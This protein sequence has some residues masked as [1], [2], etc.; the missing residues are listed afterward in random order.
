MIRSSVVYN[1]KIGVL[2]MKYFRSFCCLMLMAL[3]F[4]SAC[5]SEDK[6]LS[7]FF[8]EKGLEGT[9]IIS[10]L[11][12]NDEFVYNSE[13]SEQRFLPAS[14]F[15]IA[16]TLI[17]LEEEVISN[18]KEIIKW[19]GQNKGFKKWNRDHSLK[20]AFPV[21]CVWFYQELASRI[22]NRKYRYH[23]NQLK[24]GNMET[25][26]D[27]KSFWLKGDLKISAKEQVE[28]LKRLYLDKLPYKS[29][30]LKLVKKLMVIKKTSK[31]VLRGK[32]GWAKNPEKQHGWYVGYLETN[33][34][35][36]FFANNIKINKASDAKY[37]E[38]LV[39]K[40]F[41]AKGII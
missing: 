32:T 41:K 13:R 10:L 24:Y 33:G 30:Y 27:L 26:K 14:T 40:A 36:W 4:V 31:Y 1:F 15:K 37:R 6:D 11:N 16:N 5:K 21:S 7:I 3:A 20:T 12:G 35:V 22:G 29:A 34:N 38:E 9:C 17:A 8:K 2:T 25:G 28:F 19:D 23:L 18:E 39:L